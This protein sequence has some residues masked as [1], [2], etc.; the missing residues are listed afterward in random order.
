[1][2]IETITLAKDQAKKEWAIYK[3]TLRTHKDEYL[4]DTLKAL[5]FLRRGIEILD[6]KK[7]CLI[8]CLLIKQDY[9]LLPSLQHTG[10]GLL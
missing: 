3:E 1:M 5:S 8:K 9:L 2:K 6:V 4:K 7:N 10:K